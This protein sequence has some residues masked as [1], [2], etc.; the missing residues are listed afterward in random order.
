MDLTRHSG[1]LDDPFFEPLRRRHPD[2]DIVILPPE[3]APQEPAL[4]QVTDE[5]VAAE[6]DRIAA[7]A[8]ALWRVA[9]EDVD[10]HP[11]TFVALGD[12]PGT[13]QARARVVTR[14]PEG[15]RVLVR[16]RGELVDQGWRVDRVEG[17]VEQLL[18]TGPDAALRA[19]YAEQSGTLIVELTGLR[20]YVGTDRARALVA[21]GR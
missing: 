1:P 15:F 6:V 3:E 4:P 19:S 5:V 21:G 9:G 18:G 12:L 7:A 16:L 8:E 17:P 2:V 11:G 14:T 10:A 13:V 20:A